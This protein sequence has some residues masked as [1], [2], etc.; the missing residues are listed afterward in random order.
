MICR[1]GDHK[2]AENCGRE[3]CRH[4]LGY[5]GLPL[6]VALACSYNTMGFDILAGRVREFRRGHDRT[7]EVE[8]KVLRDTSLRCTTRI[9]DCRGANIYIVT[10]PTPVDVANE[11]D[12]GP[13]L[14]ATRAI[15]SI[16]GQ[17]QGVII[18]YESTVYPG[19][20]E[21]ICGLEIERISGLKRGRDF[22]FGYSPE[23][24]NPDD[25]EHAVDRI[26][27]VV[28]GE[29]AMITGQFAQL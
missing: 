9:E 17:G 5:V 10:V 6:A 26:T 28:A 16:L 3:N 15:A 22:F 8:P 27:K 24:A 4:W 2:Y 11:P 23:R 20:T 1:H 14:A 29:N 12:L 13:V 7:R 21:D 19:V 18:V 25:R